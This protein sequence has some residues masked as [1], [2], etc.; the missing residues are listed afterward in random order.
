MRFMIFV[1]SFIFVACGAHKSNGD[2]NSQLRAS[3]LPE[4]RLYLED[5]TAKEVN[6]N[7]IDEEYF[8]AIIAKAQAIYAPIVAKHG[9]RLEITGNWNDSTVNA[10]ANR[11]GDT[12][13]VAMFGGM[14]RRNE[15]TKD[16][17]ALVICHEIG[18]HMAGFPKYAGQWAANEGNSDFYA[19]ASCAYKLFADDGSDT[20]PEPTPSPSPKPP[21][22]LPETANTPCK[23]FMPSA[24]ETICQRAIDGAL[25]LGKLLAVLGGERIPKIE[26]PDKSVVRKTVDSHP[27]AQ[28]RLDTMYQ[29][30]LCEKSWND[31]IIPNNKQE[32]SQVSCSARPAC[33][34]KP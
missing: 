24:K 27:K 15:I 21:C 14:A 4:N 9:G 31:N 12:W 10:Y 2:G 6:A 7:G 18:H 25:S 17:F 23:S 26:T 20:T 11:S 22:F 5:D 32:M 19:T 16:G 3:F 13:E 8:N 30:I 1:L 34:Y 28:C 29:G 33:W